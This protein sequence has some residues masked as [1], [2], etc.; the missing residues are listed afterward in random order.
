M[1]PG[2]GREGRY[3]KIESTPPPP[4]RP[5]MMQD[6]D[7][8]I[9]MTDPRRSHDAGIG[10]WKSKPRTIVFADLH[11]KLYLA[12]LAGS[13]NAFPGPNASKHMLHYL[14]NTGLPL[15]IDLENMVRCVAKARAA[16]VEEVRRAQTFMQTLPIGQ[17]DIVARI[18]TPS[19]IYTTDNSDWHFALGQFVRW[20]KC[21]VR[22]DHYRGERR[23]DVDFTYKVYDRY[24]WDRGE[25]TKLLGIEIT[26]EEIGKFHLEGM[27]REYD[28]IGGLRRRL[29]WVGAI[30][31]LQE[32]AITQRSIWS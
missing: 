24:N 29:S 19:R 6:H 25:K 22:V 27:A 10:G 20:G 28:C 14:E 8:K 21:H 17:H 7:Y 16:L 31:N 3:G 26:D 15:A 1:S 13:G 9:G 4:Q 5:G 23:Y 32:D 30:T 2:N 12:L 18:A 11:T